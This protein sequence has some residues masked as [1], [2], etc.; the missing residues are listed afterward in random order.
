MTRFYGVHTSLYT[1]LSVEHVNDLEHA[2]YCTITGQY[3]AARSMFESRLSNVKVVPVVSVERAELAYR[4][5]RYKEIWETL[6]EVLP[7]VANEGTV[8]DMEDAPYRL[9]RIFHAL[10]A[11]RYKGTVEHAKGEIL[12]VRK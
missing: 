12:R 3:A 11:I 10:A 7:D 2:I 4:Q 1:S 8:H 5:G 9:M 6:E